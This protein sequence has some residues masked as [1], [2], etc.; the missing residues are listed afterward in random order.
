MGPAVSAT[1]FGIITTLGLALSACEESSLDQR[2]AVLSPIAFG[3]GDWQ[4]TSQ[5]R[6]AS[7]QVRGENR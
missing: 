6:R 2:I 5:P 1:L 7:A 3:V 4:G